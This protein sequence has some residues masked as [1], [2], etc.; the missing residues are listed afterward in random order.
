VLVRECMATKVFTVRFDKKLIAVRE[1][2][3]W[4]HLRH[5]PVVNASGEVVGIISHRDLL[6][7]ALSSVAAAPE[8][9]RAQFLSTVPIVQVM[10]TTVQTIG[11]DE[12]VQQA[13][14]LMRQAKIGCL[15]VKEHGRL[16]G[17]ISEYDLLGIVEKL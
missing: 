5:V 3:N 16:V 14:R 11:P 15:P 1:I 13:A 12:P 6:H 9:E 17:I 4:G 10:K 7:A 2:M 8:I